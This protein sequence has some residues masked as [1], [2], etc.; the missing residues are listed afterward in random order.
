MSWGCVVRPISTVA[1]VPDLRRLF[2]FMNGVHG[3][4]LLH[5][6]EMFDPLVQWLMCLFLGD[7]SIFMSGVH[8]CILVLELEI[9]LAH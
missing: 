2:I 6:P 4:I 7:F 9:C 3:C 8:G 1:D 5:D